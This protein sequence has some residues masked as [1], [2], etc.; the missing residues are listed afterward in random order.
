[1]QKIVKLYFAL[2]L[3]LTVYYFAGCSS[4]EYEVDEYKFDYT[5]KTITADTIK[6]VVI[7]END[8]KEEKKETKTDTYSFT[9]QIG[10]FVT[11]DYF[12]RFYQQAKEVL[13]N[14]VYFETTGNLN[15]IRVGKYSKRSD[16]IKYVEFCRNKGYYDAFVI[17]KKN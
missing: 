4:G 7:K 8:I 15:K 3:I 2:L 11:P 16:A 6:K 1:M 12:E 13:G 5:E 10:A 17:S 9:V 14:E